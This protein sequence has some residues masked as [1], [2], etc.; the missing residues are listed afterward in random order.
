M[1]PSIFPH[2][3][4]F[5]FPVFSSL[6]LITLFPSN[7]HETALFETRP[8]QDFFKSYQLSAPPKRSRSCLINA[9]LSQG[10]DLSDIIYVKQQGSKF[11]SWAG[12]GRK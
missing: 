7:S 11:S 9:G 1:F 12:P 10:C 4:L 6:L 8:Q 2:R 5:I 3:F